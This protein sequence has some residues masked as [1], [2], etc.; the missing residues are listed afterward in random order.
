MFPFCV[1]FRNVFFYASWRNLVRRECLLQKNLN[2]DGLAMSGSF[3]VAFQVSYSLPFLEAE[4]PISV[5]T[6]AHHW[7]SLSFCADRSVCRHNV[8]CRAYCEDPHYT[9]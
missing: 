4:S 9:D 6:A 1:I 2:V 7:Q 3:L 8:K 5:F